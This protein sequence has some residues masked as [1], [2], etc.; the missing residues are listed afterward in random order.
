MLDAL[1]NQRNVLIGLNS[2]AYDLR[3]VIAFMGA[4]FLPILAE[5]VKRKI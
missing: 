1:Q 2:R 4:F 3:S 5:I